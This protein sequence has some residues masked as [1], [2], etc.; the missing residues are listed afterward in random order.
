MLTVDKVEKT[1]PV[2][3]TD[4]QVLK[5]TSFSVARG[6]FV[7]IVG[8]SGCGK[9]T[10]LNICAGIISP[11]RGEVLI[12]NAPVRP[13][14]YGYVFQSAALLPWKTVLENVLV[15]A[16]ILKY[17][18]RFYKQKAI[19]LLELVGLK[20]SI[21]LLPG[22]LSGG[23]QQRVA[24]ARSLLTDPEILLMDEPFGALDAMTREQLNRQLSDLHLSQ[25]KTVMFV[26][27]SISEAV[28]LSD[29]IV[30]YAGRPGELV[31]DI[32]INI[33]HSLRQ[34]I[35]S[36]AQIMELEE[37]VRRTLAETE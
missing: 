7:S 21:S 28:F 10:L 23:M 26:T 17:K 29:R 9:T 12:D 37:R 5:S 15:P 22:A 20:G 27:H 6:E 19:D 14:S 36:A 34:D 31:D 4:V 18:P 13:G 35:D 3:G 11:S 25:K 2:N 8:P 33:D 32:R 24:I 16:K 30:V 1:Y